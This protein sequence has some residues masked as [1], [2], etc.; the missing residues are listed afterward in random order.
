V[1][2]VARSVGRRHPSDLG[3][4]HD[5]VDHGDAVLEGTAP[6]CSGACQLRISFCHGSVDGRVRN[7]GGSNPFDIRWRVGGGSTGEFGPDV[8][9]REPQGFI[10]SA[11]G[12]CGGLVPRF[13]FE[14]ADHEKRID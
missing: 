6:F 2:L 7:A 13:S 11:K 10:P 8:L 3:A 12:A 5:R 14:T 1:G 4:V 9:E